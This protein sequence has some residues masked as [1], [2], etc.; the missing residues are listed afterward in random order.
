MT[1]LRQ[2]QEEERGF[3]WSTKT[4]R[5]RLSPAARGHTAP[6]PILS[7]ACSWPAVT[8]A[9]S[10]WTLFLMLSHPSFSSCVSLP[11]TSTPILLLPWSL[12]PAPGLV[13]GLQMGHRHNDSPSLAC[14]TLWDKVSSQRTADHHSGQMSVTSALSSPQVHPRSP[15]LKKE[16][17]HWEWTN[18]VTGPTG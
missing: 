4:L 3:N 7:P 2:Q 18:L 1:A 16:K 8:T 17:H 11:I 5:I 10:I 13:H 12:G 14:R 9:P 15:V 6:A